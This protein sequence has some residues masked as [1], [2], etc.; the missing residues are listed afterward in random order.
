M[1]CVAFLKIHI[2]W[3][4]K[5][6]HLDKLQPWSLTARPWK[7]F[8]SK[9]IV[10]FLHLLSTELLKFT[11]A[12]KYGLW[13]EFQPRFSWNHKK[14]LLSLLSI[15]CF[16]KLLYHDVTI[17]IHRLQWQR[18][19][20]QEFLAMLAVSYHNFMANGNRNH[21][22]WRPCLLSPSAKQNMAAKIHQICHWRNTT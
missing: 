18:R 1:T 14:P 2:H 3:S 12:S 4:S 16:T 22:F 15:D 5:T 7:V 11:G 13:L 21:L 8:I 9:R 10:F 19:L 20:W 6:N 17:K